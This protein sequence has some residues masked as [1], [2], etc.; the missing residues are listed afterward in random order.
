MSKEKQTLQLHCKD[1][2]QREISE[3][4]QIH[5]KTVAKGIIPYGG[6]S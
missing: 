5:R 2:S 6:T 1:Y 3:V 4:L